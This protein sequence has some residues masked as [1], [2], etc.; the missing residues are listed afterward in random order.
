MGDLMAKVT[1]MFP[2]VLGW[3]GESVNAMATTE[4]SLSALLPFLALG[5]VVT[6][7]FAGVKMVRSFLW[8]GG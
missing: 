2:T 8:G 6:I 4:G 1:E 3:F 5:L 7:L